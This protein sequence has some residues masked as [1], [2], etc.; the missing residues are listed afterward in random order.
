[1][2]VR[3]MTLS[4]RQ[5]SV[6]EWVLVLFMTGV[7]IAALCFGAWGLWLIYDGLIYNGAS[8]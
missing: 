3:I 6:L 4:Q 7:S 2:Q 5:V 1:M 8:K